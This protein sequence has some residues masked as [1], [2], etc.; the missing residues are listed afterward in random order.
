MTQSRWS[1][2]ILCAP[3]VMMALVGSSHAAGSC[4]PVQDSTLKGFSVPRH[5]YESST[6]NG[7]PRTSEIIYIGND[8][9]LLMNG[10]WKKSPLTKDAMLNQEKENF[11]D[12]KDMSC[13]VVREEA[14]GGVPT[15]VYAVHSENEAG[16]VDT[17][18]WLSKV[19]GLPVKEEIDLDVGGGPSGKSHRSIRFAY[20]D[21]KAPI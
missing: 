14:V 6:R 8:I 17:Q 11:A 4:Q 19:S 13:R 12:T 5:L 15:I 18:L 7:Q 16:K 2:F 10:K 3:I 20:T 9:Y 21:V 1:T